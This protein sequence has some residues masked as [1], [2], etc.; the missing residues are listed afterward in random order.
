MSI[1]LNITNFYARLMVKPFLRRN[2][3]P[4]R[5]RRWL[6]NQAKYFFSKPENFWKTPTTF[7]VDNK[8]IKGLWVGSG[9][10]KKY[11]G[12]LLYI[13]GGAFI[14]GSPKTHQKLAARIAKEI[15]FKA[16]LPDYR[17]APENKYPCAVE[18]V[19]TTYQAILST[20]IK[21]SQI[22]LAGDSAGGTLVLE[23]INHLLKKKLDLPAAA[24]LLSPLT[25]LTFSGNSIK[26][27]KEAEVILPAEQID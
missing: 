9:K 11:K 21:S 13:H 5:V 15:D 12:V 20:G 8:T 24:V 16:A 22:V 19:I 10:N 1:R 18:D 25:D 14:F 6:E 4:Y 23:L 27:N 17:L 2:K 3:D 26:T 7:S